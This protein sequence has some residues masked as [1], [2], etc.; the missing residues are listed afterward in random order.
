MYIK[1]D[2]FCRTPPGSLSHTVAL[3]IW[4]LYRRRRRQQ[5][6]LGGG[7]S[8]A[9]TLAS[10]STFTSRFSR[11]LGGH[12]RMSVHLC[13]ICFVCVANTHAAVAV[14]KHP[15]LNGHLNGHLNRTQDHRRRARTTRT[16]PH[17]DRIEEQHPRWQYSVRKRH[18]RRHTSW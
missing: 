15:H 16:S 13:S 5:A 4:L 3:I 6:A 12:A 7:P 17:C 14:R 8:K 9:A 18:T 10:A 2:V 1:L 11:T